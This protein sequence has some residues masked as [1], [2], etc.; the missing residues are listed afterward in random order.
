[1]RETLSQACDLAARLGV[2]LRHTEYVRTSPDMHI[3]TQVSFA[4]YARGFSRQQVQVERLDWASNEY[5]K[6][7]V[8]ECN[9]WDIDRL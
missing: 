9:Q 8:P 5:L 1:M 4:G 3:H 6:T 7:S 2:E